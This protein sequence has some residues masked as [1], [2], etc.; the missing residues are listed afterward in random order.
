M[1]YTVKKRVSED[2]PQAQTI[3][4]EVPIGTKIGDIKQKIQQEE[5]T[6]SIIVPKR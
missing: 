5:G 4:I 2:V 3:I 1:K 6:V